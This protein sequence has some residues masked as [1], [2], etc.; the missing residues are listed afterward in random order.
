MLAKYVAEVVERGLEN[1]KDNGGDI[2]DQV[3][4]TNQVIN[5]IIDE[6]KGLDFDSLTVSDRAEQLFGTF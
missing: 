5:T 2:N 6:T 4:L 3:T 1:L